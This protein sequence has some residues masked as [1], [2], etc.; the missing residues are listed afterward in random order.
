MDVRV[1]ALLWLLLLLVAPRGRCQHYLLLRPIP[2]DSLPLLELKEDPDPIFDPRERDLNETELRA[3]LGDFDGRFL[4]VAAPPPPPPPGGE[5]DGGGGFGRALSADELDD[6][7][8]LKLG[9][10]LPKEL[11]VADVD[12]QLGK[13]H[14]PSK[15]LRR[16]LQQWLWAYT[17]CP[18]AHAW[19]DLGSRF[20]P[21]YV[22]T[23]SCPSKRS[24]SVPEGMVCRPAASA[25]LSLLRWRCVQRKGGLKCAWIPVQ[26]SVITD[27]KCACAS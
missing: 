27:C 2:S 9:G 13:R 14:K 26:Y 11:R 17:A 16:R 4:S 12:A 10:A 22:R 23:G 3:V 7:D 25:H 24:C 1:A 19:T 15:K 18:V 21:R 8:A 20:W 5:E 6:W